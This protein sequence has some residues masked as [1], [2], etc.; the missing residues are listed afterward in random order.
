MVLFSLQNE[1]SF[2][3]MKLYEDVRKR[4]PKAYK[5]LIRCLNESGNLHAV[6]ILEPLHNGPHQMPRVY[7]ASPG[8]SS[9]G[10]SIGNG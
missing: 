9:G 4:G 3:T 2:R 1:S 10:K 6:Q 8:H 7:N 5:N